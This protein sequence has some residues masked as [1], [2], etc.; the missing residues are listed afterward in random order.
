MDNSQHV[1]DPKYKKSYATFGL[2][3][4]L[5]QIRHAI[6]ERKNADRNMAAL[7]RLLRQHEQRIEQRLNRSL[8]NLRILEIGPGQG[9]ERARYF[10]MKNEVVALDLDVIPNRSNP[11]SYLHMLKV[12]GAG[13]FLKSLGRRLII[14]RRNESAWARVIGADQLR[15]PAFIQG[16]ICE[17]VPVSGAF[18]LIVSWSVFEHLPDPKKALAN[19][20]QTLKPGGAFYISL[21]LFTSINGSHDIRAFTGEEDQLPLWGHLR[22]AVSHLIHP[23]AYLNEWRLSQWRHLFSEMTP[24]F[25]EYLHAYDYQEK[26]G[27]LLA[28]SL[29]SELKDYSNEELFTVDA[30]YLWQKPAGEPA[31]RNGK[32]V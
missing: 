7:Y 25:E 23:S 12:N 9:L 15:D 11:G 19:V 14:G 1:I 31:S 17:N 24:G 20:I 2:K 18:D 21:H 10:G 3:R 8:Q 16:D 6:S 13:R 27:P 30:V 4:S 32:K 5:L 28:G 29:R 26:Y 22:P